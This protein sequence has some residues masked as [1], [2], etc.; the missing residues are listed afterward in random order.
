MDMIR[1]LL[2]LSMV[3]LLNY[4]IFFLIAICVC[5]LLLAQRWRWRGIIALPFCVAILLFVVD[6]SWIS[7]EMRRPGWDG[8][9]DMDI[10]FIIGYFMRVF[11]FNTLLTAI[12]WYA[13]RRKGSSL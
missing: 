1:A 11:L 7:E 4:G 10:V 13:I 2:W 6:L 9:P 12:G 5:G 3:Q 8:V